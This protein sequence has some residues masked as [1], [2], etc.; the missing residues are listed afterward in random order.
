MAALADLGPE[1]V[2]DEDDLVPA[3]ETLIS[4]ARKSKLPAV[5]PQAEKRE[6]RRTIF[7]RKATAGGQFPLCAWLP[8]SVSPL[9]DRRS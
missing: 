7:L 5:S 9:S 8:W 1:A 6:Y 3:S 2:L 4:L